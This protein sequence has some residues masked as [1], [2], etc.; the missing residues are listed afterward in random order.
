MGAVGA[1]RG[2][3]LGIPPTR[4]KGPLDHPCARPR[5][6]PAAIGAPDAVKNA[7]ALPGAWSG[8]SAPVGRVA[9]R[10]GTDVR[11]GPRPA[12]APAT[13]AATGAL[14]LLAAA[15]VPAADPVA[16]LTDPVDV[17]LPALPIA[18]PNGL[19]ALSRVV[20]PKLPERAVLTVDGGGVGVPPPLITDDN[21]ADTTPA[22]GVTAC[23]SVAVTVRLAG[24]SVATTAVVT[25]ATVLETVLVAAVVTGAS[26]LETVLVAAVVTGA[27]TLET[28]LVAA[29][30]TGASTLE[31]VLVAAVVT[32]ASTLETVLVAAVV[33]GRAPWRRCWW[34]RW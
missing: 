3:P 12:G 1:G 8:I 32:G 26:T 20:G 29:V 16:G 31:T 14:G 28:V 13:G 4:A 22:T 11:T 2:I 33:T 10:N 5:S 34:R 24:A 18:A 17:D 25:G 30:V 15:G 9:G 19:V 21:L 23:E 6:S 27:S 7:N